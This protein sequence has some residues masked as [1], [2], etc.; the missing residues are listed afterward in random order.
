MSNCEIF[1]LMFISNLSMCDSFV[2]INLI[3]VSFMYNPYLLHNRNGILPM[4]DY[5][6]PKCFRKR[7]A[8][9]H[10]LFKF[11]SNLATQLT[12]DYF[13]S[14]VIHE[15]MVKD[16]TCNISRGV[17][18]EGDEVQMVYATTCKILRKSVQM[19]HHSYIP[20]LEGK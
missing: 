17:I 12:M 10:V 5:S 19:F 4:H 11:N 13:E 3:K 20:L 16:D 9:L 2:S 15:F 14:R 6:H 8:I 7:L 18:Y 1:A